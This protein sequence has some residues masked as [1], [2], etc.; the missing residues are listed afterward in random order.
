MAEGEERMAR[1]LTPQAVLGS[2]H[3][4]SR[5]AGKS[6]TMKVADPRKSKWAPLSTSECMPAPMPEFI[7]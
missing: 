4:P 3:H 7:E 2:H 6:S 1:V 5:L